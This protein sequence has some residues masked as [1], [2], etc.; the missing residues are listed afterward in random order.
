MVKYAF[1]DSLRDDY[2]VTR[3]CRWAQVS[4]SGYYKW[5]RREPSERD[6]RKLE[7]ERLLVK[8]FTA[9]DR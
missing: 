9:D 8:L 2:A 3:M 7:A 4:R 6:L 1:I 5:R